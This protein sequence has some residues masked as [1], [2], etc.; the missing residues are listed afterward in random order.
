MTNPRAEEGEDPELEASLSDAGRPAAVP[1]ESDCPRAAWVIESLSRQPAVELDLDLVEHLSSCPSCWEIAWIQ[2]ETLEEGAAPGSA[3]IPPLVEAAVREALDRRRGGREQTPPRLSRW[4]PWRPLLA[5]ALAA[6]L[7]LLL[8]PWAFSQSLFDLTSFPIYPLLPDGSEPGPRNDRLR[9]R[10]KLHTRAHVYA[11]IAYTLGDEWTFE[12]IEVP[13]DATRPRESGSFDVLGN[14]P[15]GALEAR[16]VLLAA[17]DPL[18]ATDRS[19]VEELA[20]KPRFENAALEGIARARR[21]E[22]R[23][24]P[25]LLQDRGTVPVELRAEVDQVLASSEL[26]FRT[27]VEEHPKRAAAAVAEILEAELALESPTPDSRGFAQAER[28]AKRYGLIHDRDLLL[29]QVETYRSW[30]ES[31]QKLERKRSLDRSIRRDL[32]FHDQNASLFSASADPLELYEASVRLYQEAADE[33]AKLGDRW[34]EIESLLRRAFFDHASGEQAF[35]HVIRMSV[36][37]CYPRAE[38]LARNLEVFVL[39][40]GKVP[41]EFFRHEYEYAWD[42]LD[43][44]RL[45]E[46]SAIARSNFGLELLNRGVASQAFTYLEKAL[47]IQQALGFRR[48]EAYTLYKLAWAHK[49][50]GRAEAGLALARRA[51]RVLRECEPDFPGHAVIQLPL[52]RV[53]WMAASTAL[54]CDKPDLALELALEGERITH[55]FTPDDPDD[56]SRCLNVAARAE[57]ARG[58]QVQ[59]EEIA[60]RAH[61]AYWDPWQEGQALATR[62]L[63]IQTELERWREALESFSDARDLLGQRVSARFDLAELLEGKAELQEDHDLWDEA[64]E[65]RLDWLGIVKEILSLN[66]VNA[67]DRAFLRE[68]FR[69]GFVAGLKLAHRLQSSEPR[70]A[71]EVALGF[72]E[73]ARQP[74]TVE[75]LEL[76]EL[77]SSLPRRALWLE[78]IFGDET[79]YLFVVS[80]QGG[81]LVELTSTRTEAAERLSALEGA[82]RAQEAID[83]V[84]LAG[85][86]AFD[87]LLSPALAELGAHDLL[88]VSLD[89]G[90]DAPL[91]E[92]FVDGRTPQGEPNYLLL[93]HT[94]AYL[95]SAR[96]LV[97]LE[98]ESESQST[99]GFLGLAALTRPQETRADSDEVGRIARLFEAHGI[100]ARI[101]QGTEPEFVGDPGSFFARARYVHCRTP[102]YDAAVLELP[103]ASYA[104]TD[105]LEVGQ[106]ADLPRLSAELL[107]L[108]SGEG[109]EASSPG[110][111]GGFARAF[112]AQ[113]AR[114]VVSDLWS[115]DPKTH[116]DLLARFYER[117]LSGEEKSVALRGAKLEH[118]R[119]G[120]KASGDSSSLV[121]STH[122][123]FWAT[124][125]L[126][127]DP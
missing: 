119:G 96:F 72:L 61:D 105:L 46:V 5:A 112:L 121:A 93:D 32:A 73:A 20:R 1:P 63:S 79:S 84:A 8:R 62:G 88:F 55:E 57:L 41:F 68:R 33:Y 95:P 82:I 45:W 17:R 99:M 52:A 81:R 125:V 31:P 87:H 69:G 122:P 101:I 127:G 21:G 80:A 56:R 78:Y 113:G 120:V 115:G 38:A 49:E 89:P 114:T 58:N 4:R 91:F 118:L 37:S 98:T 13:G 124:P 27:W 6:G 16:W 92:V 74:S 117:T 71:C 28:I 40:Q 83:R 36:E 43:E 11:G 108:S 26:E 44:I 111:W 51:I 109:L 34:G 77:Q 126:V 107:V 59:A 22:L 25:V 70:K 97:D 110:E 116:A 12:W 42:L 18:E 67:V 29:E 14:I 39:D 15:A 50:F 48:D 75:R 47:R 66:D 7:L 30:A 2:H 106:I 123:W 100:A 85:Q 53:H 19:T 94:V 3:P 35:E 76:S 90:V 54:A 102:L 24:N 65:T 9:L 60:R 86:S 64:L 10:V 23:S 104:E 103:G